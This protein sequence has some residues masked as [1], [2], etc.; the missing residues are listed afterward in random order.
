MRPPDA[1]QNDDQEE[2]STPD[3]GVGQLGYIGFWLFAIV[4]IVLIYRCN[5]VALG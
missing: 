3:E 5:G 1:E 2:D 4:L